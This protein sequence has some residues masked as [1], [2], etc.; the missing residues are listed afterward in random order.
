[1]KSKLNDDNFSC[2]DR[3]ERRKR[4][5]SVNIYHKNLTDYKSFSVAVVVV[6][7]AVEPKKIFMMKIF[8]ILPDEIIFIWPFLLEL[9]A[10][11]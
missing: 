2:Y 7:A 8:A 6:A 9:S 1:M 10:L 11:L 5:F 3:S 4:N